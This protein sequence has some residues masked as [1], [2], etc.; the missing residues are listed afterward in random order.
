MTFEE[1]VARQVE[2][3]VHPGELAPLQ[4]GPLHL[5]VPAASRPLALVSLFDGSGLA[6]CAVDVLTAA[7][8]QQGVGVDQVAS[9]CAEVDPILANAVDAAGHVYVLGETP[10]SRGL[11]VGLPPSLPGDDRTV[12][13]AR[14]RCQSSTRDP[15]LGDRRQP[16]PGPHHG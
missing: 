4:A 11:C 15:H 13:A 8:R 16:M 12:P 10:E 3:Q 9:I 1:Q 2:A 14:L 5:P 6:R 7:F